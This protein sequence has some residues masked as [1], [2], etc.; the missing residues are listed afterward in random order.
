MI[1]YVNKMTAFLLPTWLE[2][3]LDIIGYDL[4]IPKA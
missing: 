3:K 2:S 4:Y 1:N